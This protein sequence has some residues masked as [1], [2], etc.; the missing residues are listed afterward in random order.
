[1]P[2]REDCFA[3][4]SIHDFAFTGFLSMAQIQQFTL[5]GLMPSQ[6]SPAYA[7]PN[8]VQLP[9]GGP[10]GTASGGGAY[11]QAANLQIVGG[12][13]QSEV[14]TVSIAGSVGTITFT[15]YA[16]KPYTCTFLNNDSLAT[17]QTAMQ[18]I[19]GVGN[20]TVTGTAGTTYTCTL[21]G[22]SA[23]VRI[24]GYMTVT[25]STSGTPTIA[26]TTRGCSGAGQY[27]LYAGSGK[28]NA[29]L[30][31]GFSTDPQGCPVTDIPSSGQPSTMPAWN[32][33]RFFVAQLITSGANA[34]DA[35]AMSQGNI[36]YVRGA[37][38]TDTGAQVEII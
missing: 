33:G 25:A 29:F 20:V 4:S 38:L 32:R 15:F 26:R 18:T 3:D 9:W 13:V 7:V 5:Q 6:D 1:M 12:T 22:T 16:N 21:G 2:S 19:F 31:Y 36:V 28:V 10:Y 11:S 24:G 8:P 35:N 17:V 27:D 34:L 30:E 14:Y 23:N 37:A